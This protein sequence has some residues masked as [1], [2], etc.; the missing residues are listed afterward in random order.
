MEG[1]V[2]ASKAEDS[3]ETSKE[4]YGESVVKRSDWKEE[5]DG[6]E[7]SDKWSK[8]KEAKEKIVSWKRTFLERRTCLVWRL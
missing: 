1:W 8:E 5:F 4:T 7:P 2:G 3:L 6:D